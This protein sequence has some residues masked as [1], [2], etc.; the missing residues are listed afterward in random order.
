M[1]DTP[2]AEAAA[3]VVR[4]SRI[5]V[6]ALAVGLFLLTVVFAVIRL[7]GDGPD[8]A[9]PVLGLFALGFFL[10]VATTRSIQLSVQKAKAPVAPSEAAVADANDSA[11]LLKP[12]TDAWQ[13]RQVIG[14]ALI[15]GPALFCTIVALIGPI[16]AFA[17]SIVGIVWLL[18]S[19]P[20]LQSFGRDITAS[21]QRLD[22]IDS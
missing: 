20:S 21:R 13:T 11:S 16:W 14:A 17:G 5:L 6:A 7:T 1:L 4:T 3:P 22:P 15:E 18:L 9:N 2:T 8:E 12:F 19:I 10:F